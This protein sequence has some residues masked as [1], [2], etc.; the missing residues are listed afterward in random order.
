M[1]CVSID[2]E[3]R[4]LC[5]CRQ[6]YRVVQ[7]VASCTIFMSAALFVRIPLQEHG[8]G[9]DKINIKSNIAEIPGASHGS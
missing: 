1:R 5:E 6:C 3:K 2:M 9:V 7:L 8:D 4:C